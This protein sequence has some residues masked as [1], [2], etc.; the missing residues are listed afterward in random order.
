MRAILAGILLLTAGAVQAQEAA[1]LGWMAGDWVEV[2]DGQ[3]TEEVWLAPRGGR[4]IGM[5]R[6]GKT[7]ARGPFEYMR[8]EAGLDGRLTFTAQPN[9]AKP[10]GFPLETASREAIS[11]AN[12][13][14]DY[15]QRVRY[16]REGELLLAEVSLK[17][18]SK[19]QRWRYQRRR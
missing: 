18:G 3:V 17:D 4:L 13:A 14:H 6:T 15:P 7:D 1:S 5:G 11:F 16:W 19:A 8:I 2:K 10:S 12:P 9:G